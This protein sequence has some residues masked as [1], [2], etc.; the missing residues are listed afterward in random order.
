MKEQEELTLRDRIVFKTLIKGINN[1]RFIVAKPMKDGKITVKRVSLT[2]KSIIK[3]DEKLFISSRVIADT[4]RSHGIGH[5][6]SISI[7]NEKMRVTVI[8]YDLI[9]EK[10]G[11][12]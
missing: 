7:K 2:L 12:E 5:S 1:G 6:Q 8:N 11:V 10:L 9:K 4:L 3:L